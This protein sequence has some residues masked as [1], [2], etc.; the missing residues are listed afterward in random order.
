MYK[1]Y[2]IFPENY[3]WTLSATTCLHLGGN[4]GELMALCQT[5]QDASRVGRSGD[6]DAWEAGWSEL[7]ER[8]FKMAQEE[9]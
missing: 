1:T 4:M 3:A 6:L 9:E 5:L 8:V 7:A 2:H